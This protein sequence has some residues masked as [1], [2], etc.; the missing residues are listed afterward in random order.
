M[1]IN[2]TPGYIRRLSITGFLFFLP[3]LIYLIIFLA[4]PIVSAIVLSFTK[5]TL[6]SAPE[7]VG[8]KNY[9]RVLSMPSFWN[10]LGVTGLYV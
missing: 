2:T 8:F 5:Y 10:S 4:G 9:L 3:A 7:L 1:S 6:L